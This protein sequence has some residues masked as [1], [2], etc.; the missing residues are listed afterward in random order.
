MSECKVI[1]PTSAKTN[2]SKKDFETVKVA[3][4]VRPMNARGNV[5][6]IVI[7]YN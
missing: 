5:F 1:S 6:I 7:K 3:V 2:M 4:R